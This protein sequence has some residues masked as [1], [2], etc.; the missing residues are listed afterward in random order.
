MEADDGLAPLT[1]A[2]A[3]RTELAD[4]LRRHGITLPSLRV[5]AASCAGRPARPLIDLGRCDVR[6]TR[7]L[8]AALRAVPAEER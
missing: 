7:H 6:T 1:D 5:D 3:A 8:S 2:E 4:A